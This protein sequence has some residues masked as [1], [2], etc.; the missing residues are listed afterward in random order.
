[1]ETNENNNVMREVTNYNLLPNNTFGIEA[2]CERFIEYSSVAE[3]Q[4]TARLINDSK[5]PLLIIGA[6]S[7][8]L[9]TSD[10]SGIVVHSTIKGHEE[11]EDP[12]TGDT[13]MRCGSGMTWDDIVALCVDNGWHGAENLSLIPGEVGASAIQNIGAYG[14]EAKDIIEKV[15]AVSVETGEVV[16]FANAD[17]HYAYRDSRFKHEWKNKYLITYVTYR[18]TKAFTPELNYGN[19]RKSLEEKGISTPSAAQLRQVIIETRQ[20]K[21]PDPTV[22]GNAGSFF[23][24]P[25]VTNDTLEKLKQKYDNIPHYTIDDQHVKIPAGWMIEQ[26]GWKGRILGHAGVHN[27]QAL[28]LVNHGGATGNEILELCNQI[29]SDVKNTFGIEIRPEVNII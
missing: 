7:N 16:T 18:F 1:M 14:A 2:H 27:K 25:I 19:I 8:L 12:K 11:H 24:N 6:G 5:K 26:C 15:E 29:I 9:L 23:M 22:L 21:L 13:L 3:A 4:Q 28:V 20:A 17:C 10:F